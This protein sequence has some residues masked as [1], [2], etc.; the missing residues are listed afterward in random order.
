MAEL[1]QEMRLAQ[2]VISRLV[3]EGKLIEVEAVEG[4]GERLFLDP[5]FNFDHTM[6]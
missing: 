6:R 2:L 5:N 4:R 1:R 3:K